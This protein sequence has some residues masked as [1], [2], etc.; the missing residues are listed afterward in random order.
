MMN[1]LVKERRETTG[2]E[3]PSVEIKNESFN[4]IIQSIFY[5]RNSRNKKQESWR[6]TVL[7]F[8]ASADFV[9]VAF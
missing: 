6:F 4:S 7:V 1:K 9:S 3:E 8:V 5:S 2:E